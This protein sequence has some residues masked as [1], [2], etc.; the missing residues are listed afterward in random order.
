MDDGGTR[1][2]GKF[3]S[4]SPE[5]PLVTI[6]TVVLNGE[7]HLEQSIR[8]VCDQQ[9]PNIEY[10]IIDGGSTDGTLD[11]IHKYE[12]RIDY[13]I[14]EPD[15]GIYDAMNKGISLARGEW[16]YFLGADDRLS[17]ADTISGLKSFLMNNST[18]VCGKVS[19]QDNRVVQSR[20]SLRTYM[21]NT[22]HHQ[23]AFYHKHLFEHWKYDATLQVMADYELNLMIYL[24]KWGFSTVPN[25]IAVCA[26]GGISRTQLNK[27]FH[28]TNRIRGRHVKPAVNKLL[29][30]LFKLQFGLYKIVYS[31]LF[32]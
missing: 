12:D 29:S 5:T 25:L 7:K 10:F 4:S 1:S 18:V 21:H 31:T 9:Y 16:L 8:S 28:E 11:I 6:I 15:G 30:L 2:G 3:K 24:N 27:A 14:S 22:V 20:F 26:D 23:A 17:A 32:K 19:Y 13:W